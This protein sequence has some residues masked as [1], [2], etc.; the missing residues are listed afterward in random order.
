MSTCN[1]FEVYV[2]TDTP[3]LSAKYILNKISECTELAKSKIRIRTSSDAVRHLFRVS[4]GLE[5]MV[6]G[7]VEIAGQI[8]QALREAQ[9]R[10]HTSRITEA[11]FQ[12]ASEVSKKVA[13]ETG[14]G[15]A[16]RSLITG[17]I[18]IVKENGFGLRAKKAL[19]I[20][21]GAYARVVTSA[22]E[23]EEVSEIF[24]YSNS[25]RAEIF[26]ESHGTTPITQSG[27][28]QALEA[29]DLIVAC[30]GTHGTIITTEDLRALNKDVLPAVSYTHLTLPT[31]YSV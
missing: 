29:C 20:G 3:D 31:I 28:H 16:G 26:A 5:S 10:N 25:G 9:L 23:R 30:S 18:D 27:L 2:D 17:G 4:A 15:A 6:V 22:L 8:K 19:V 21:T 13:T 11:L 7:E 14:L 24:T 1:R 12:R